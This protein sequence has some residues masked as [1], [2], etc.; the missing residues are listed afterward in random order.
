MKSINIWNSKFIKLFTLNIKTIYSTNATKIVIFLSPILVTMSLLFMM[1]IY[2]AIGALQIFIVTTSA[3][4]IWGML[5]YKTKNTNFKKNLFVSNIS[6]FQFYLSILICM[7][8]V[9]TISELL[10]WCTI[11]FMD[12]LNVTTL[13]EILRILPYD[14]LVLNWDKVDWFV[15]IYIWFLG[16][17]IMFVIAFF[18]RNFFNTIKNYFTIFFIYVFFLSIFGQVIRPNFEYYNGTTTE[19]KG[20]IIHENENFI[21]FISLFLPQSHLNKMSFAAISSGTIVNSTSSDLFETWGKFDLFSSFVW[22]DDSE[23]NLTIIY[24]PILIVSFLTFNLI[25]YKIHK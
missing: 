23:W 13:I 4:V 14:N 2:F 16:V 3:G 19:L 17:L 21:H 6:T 24:P 22:S 25:N 8:F 10:S 15:I 5:Y 1:P 12:F 18:T 7:L 11:F 9:T 20:V